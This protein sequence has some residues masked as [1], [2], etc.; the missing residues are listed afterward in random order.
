[1]LDAFIACAVEATS[2]ASNLI[3]GR[4]GGA[5]GDVPE[6]ATALSGRTAEW[7]FHCYAIWTERNDARHIAWARATEEALRPWTVPG[8]ALNFMTDIDDARVRATFGSEKYQRLVNLK[9]RWDPAN[10]FAINQNIQPGALT[11]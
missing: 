9:Q 8:M 5:Y 2:P 3:L 4:L 10:V 6:N 1:M 7:L 11:T